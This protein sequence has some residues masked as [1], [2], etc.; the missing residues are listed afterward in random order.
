MIATPAIVMELA[1]LVMMLLTTE[2]LIMRQKDVI[3]REVISIINLPRALNAF[4]HAPHV[5]TTHFAP[6]AI[7]DTRFSQTTHAQA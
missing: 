2:S 7:P 5:L 1:S 4:P 3:L 6:L